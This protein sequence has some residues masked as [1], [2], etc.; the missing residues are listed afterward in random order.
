M[1]IVAIAKPAPLTKQPIIKQRKFKYFYKN[2][3]FFHNIFVS[4]CKFYEFIP[5]A[6]SKAM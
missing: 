3:D 6:P 2:I 4:F 5:M 1:S